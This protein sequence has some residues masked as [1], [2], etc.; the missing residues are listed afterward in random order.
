MFYPSFNT[1]G[2]RGKQFI[3]KN[4]LVKLL[5]RYSDIGISLCIW[6]LVAGTRTCARTCKN[7]CLYVNAHKAETCRTV[8]RKKTI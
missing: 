8:A 5:G 3:P 2:A 1:K 4:N 6:T 7:L